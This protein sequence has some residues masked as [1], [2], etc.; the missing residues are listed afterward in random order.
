MDNLN[1]V[2]QWLDY[3]KSIS[4]YRLAIRAN[5]RRLWLGEETIF[6]FYDGMNAAITRHLT[7]AWAEGAAVCGIAENEL[8]ADER[9]ARE[10][11][12]NGQF[13]FLPGFADAIEAN[14]KAAGGKLGP[15]FDRADRWVSQYDK[16]KSNAKAMA[17]G[18]RKAKFILGPTEKHCRTCSGLNG[19]V[20]R[21]SVWVA[22]GAVPPKNANFECG[23][24]SYCDCRLEDTND[25]I[26][27]GPF[28]RGLLR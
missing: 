18:D 28:P 8:T 10:D 23:A 7:R 17:C 20:Y 3:T 5:V 16:A 19:R 13:T 14:S 26:T 21:Y 2:Q 24:A 25:S 27:P 22:N 4:E 15:L 1:Q 6:A 12:I 9:K 11:F